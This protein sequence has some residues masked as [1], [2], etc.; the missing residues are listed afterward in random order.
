M[1]APSAM[2]DRRAALEAQ[3]A[4]QSG[5]PQLTAEQQAEADR[6]A[7]AATNENTNDT[8]RVTIS[9]DEF[10]TLQAARDRLTATERR[11]EATRAD[12]EALQSRLTELED[13]AKGSSKPAAPARQDAPAHEVDATE[14][15]LTD[16]EK[17][18]FEEDTIAL[19]LKVANTVFTKRIAAYSTS[20]EDRI[21]SVESTANG[22]ASTVGRAA[23]TTF[24]AQVKQKVAEFSDFDKIVG[25][26]HW[27]AFT[28]AADELTGFSYGEIIQKNLAR[29]NVS[30]MV[31]VF[32]LFYDK[33]LK[34]A[35]PTNGYAGGVPSGTGN[36]DTGGSEESNKPKTLKYS[37]RLKAHKDYLA[38]DIT[39][40]EYQAI[41]NDF[42]VADREG[43]VDYNS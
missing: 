35:S 10:N 19:M 9:R 27:Q 20:V 6:I 24:T 3:A 4:E 37:D 17:A 21:K 32:K 39:Y 15:S 36:V 42:D 40:D 31:K 28:E 11:A 2:Q 13:A 41:K 14:I 12:L 8:T 43:R 5:T 29:Q 38:R 30:G 25:H 33:Y 34:D 22:A 18:D 26:Q 1:P 16:K 23:A 7:A